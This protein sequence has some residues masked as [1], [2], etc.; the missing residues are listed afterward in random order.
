MPIAAVTALRRQSSRGGYAPKREGASNT[1][2]NIKF[3]K[4]TKKDANSYDYQLSTAKL[5]GLGG[6]QS[7]TDC[8]DY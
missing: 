3:Q 8:I 4:Q 7:A 2:V 5:I 1:Q 6:G